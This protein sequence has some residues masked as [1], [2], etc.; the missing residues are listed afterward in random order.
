VPPQATPHNLPAPTTRFIGRGRELKKLAGFLER[1]DC[2]LVTLLGLGGSGKTRLALECAK[3]HLTAF[4]DG[5][6]FVPLAGVNSAALLAPSIASALGVALTGSDAPEAQLADFLRDKELLLL[7]DNVEHLTGGALLLEALLEAAPGLKL[8]VTSRLALELPGEWLLDVGGLDYPPENAEEPLESFAAVKLF[9]SRAERLSSGFVATGAILTAVASL[10]R[11]VEGLPLALELAAS[12]TRS[13]SVPELAKRLE[14]GFDALAT[15]ARD[16]PERQ[17]S[18]RAVLDY[19]WRQLGEGERE[20][21]MRLSLFHGGFTLEAAERVA[22]ANVGLLLRFINHALVRRHQAGRYDIHELVRQYL[23][24]RFTQEERARS[25]EAFCGYFAL[26]L[27]GRE[28]ALKEGDEKAALDELA[29]EAD[30]LRL[31]WRH[32]AEAADMAQLQRMAEGY[33]FLLDTKGWYQVGA[34]AFEDAAR[35][36]GTLKESPPRQAAL[37]GLLARAG[38]F[39][40][41]LGQLDV[42][43]HSLERGLRLLQDLPAPAAEGFAQHYLGVLAFVAGDNLEAGRRYE[44]ALACYERIGDAWSMTRTHNNLGVL[45]DTLADYDAAEHWYRLALRHSKAAGHLRG[46]ASA[47]VNLG[48]TLETLGRL[49]AA[50]AH[51]RE[52][53]EVYREVGDVR[54]EAA[55]LTNLGHVKERKRRL[56]GAGT[57]ASGSDHRRRHRRGGSGNGQRGYRSRP[58]VPPLSRHGDSW[59]HHSGDP[60]GQCRLCT[61][62]PKLPVARGKQTIRALRRTV[63]LSP[64]AKGVTTSL[65]TRMILR[66][67]SSCLFTATGH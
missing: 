36:L 50:E 28:R 16:L 11:R 3:A 57:R 55:S 58:R 41:R 63:F 9:V 12:W 21:L 66:A 31:A 25:L 18:L 45:A 64:A 5:V 6:R 54:G 19:I 56:Y 67:L 23:G 4:A 59:R 26:F 52:S 2:R 27:A 8:L 42:A 62:S 20:V 14:E 47:L 24:E 15:A 22:E 61:T 32:A 60:Q 34:E 40:F 51:Y 53:L 1:P 46:V 43:K 33:H 10:C 38:Y 49:E 30:N 29:A 37:G 48:V 17:R 35:H 65:R 13:L 39:R 44:Q 7:L